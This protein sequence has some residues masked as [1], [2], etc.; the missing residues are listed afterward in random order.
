MYT[1]S[2]LC[3]F[4]G[5]YSLYNTSKKA[6]LHRDYQIEIWLQKNKKSAQLIA[7][8][9]LIASLLILIAID[10]YQAGT[11]SFIVLLT[12]IAS[13]VVI[14]SPLKIVKG[15]HLVF[16]IS[17]LIVSEFLIFN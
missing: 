12:A 8:F 1:L 17:F 6:S 2:A 13:L 14:F 5:F 11:F 7:I 3:C 15:P 4:L 10:S 16:M 9:F